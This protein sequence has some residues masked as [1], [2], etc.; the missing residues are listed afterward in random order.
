[1]VSVSHDLRVVRYLSD[2]VSQ[3]EMLV[4]NAPPP[5]EIARRRILRRSW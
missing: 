3:E 2:E 1:M 4:G 5:L